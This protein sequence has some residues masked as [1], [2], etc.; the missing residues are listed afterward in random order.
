MLDGCG[1]LFIDEFH[2]HDPGDAMLL[3][4]LVRA[5]SQRRIPLVA[6]S[7]YAPDDL[8]PN[9]MHQHLV[10]PLV[11]MLKEVC[12]LVNVDG[13]VDYRRSGHGGADRLCSRLS[14]LASA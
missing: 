13:P 1:L 12:R 14:L 5:A 2:A 8:L 4:R 7:N 10:L 6:T 3:A 9:P 11:Q